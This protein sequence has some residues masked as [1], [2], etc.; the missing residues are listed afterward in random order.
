MD[1]PI[2]IFAII[3]MSHFLK[4]IIRWEPKTISR[5]GRD[6]LRLQDE[7]RDIANIDCTITPKTKA[8]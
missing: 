4:F 8:Q 2:I 7:Y 6:V 1:L 3:G 5:L